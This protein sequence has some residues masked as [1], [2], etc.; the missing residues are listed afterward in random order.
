MFY[1]GSSRAIA[2]VGLFQRVLH[3]TAQYLIAYF[4]MVYGC[5]RVECIFA[6]Q[7]LKMSA[8]GDSEQQHVDPEQIIFQGLDVK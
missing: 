5:R 2:L 3:I 8:F 6:R 1:L 7:P 4:G